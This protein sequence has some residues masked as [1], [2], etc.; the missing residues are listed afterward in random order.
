VTWSVDGASTVNCPPVTLTADTGG[1]TLSCTAQDADTTVTKL[2]PAIRID[3]TAPA[4]VTA[5]AARGPD[6]AGGW[7]TAPVALSWSGT[8]A[9]SGI[10]SCAAVT[11]A[12]PDDGA[13]RPTGSCRDLAGNVAAPV[14]FGLAYD[15]TP[16][17]LTGV[18][19]R[20]GIRAAALRWT[21]P[22]AVRVIVVRR[23]RA[24]RAAPRTVLDGPPPRVLTDRRLTPGIRYSWTVTALDAAGNAASA[25]IAATPAPAHLRWRAVRGAHYYNVQLFRGGRKVLSAW[26]GHARYRLRPAWRYRGRSHTLA[27]GVYRWYVWPGY[28]PRLRHRYGGLAARGRFRVG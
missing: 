13:A 28:G 21:A 15:A 19:A 5:T 12:G 9:T 27:A 26:P 14:P 4:G 11:Y 24:A 7:Y 16:P 2:T 22:E 17:A 10:A 18:T 20:A 1:V 6:S 23:A 25:T 3:Q 8:D